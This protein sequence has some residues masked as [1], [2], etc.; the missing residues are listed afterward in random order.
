MPVFVATWRFG[1]PACRAGWRILDAGGS[2]LDAVEAGGN[3]VEEDISVMSVGRGGL[4]N[5]EGVVELDA[6][7]MDGRT[8][9]AGAVGA[10]PGIA[11]AISVARRV[12]DRTPHV[13]LAG[14]N[15]LRFALE[16]GF[17]EEDLSSAESRARRQSWLDEQKAAQVA[18][19]EMPSALSPDE[20]HDTVGLLALDAN[21][22]LAAG[23]TTSGL[24]WKR[25]GRVGDSPIVGSGLYVD[26][27]FGAAAATGHGDEMMKACLSYRVVDRMASG[28]TPEEACVEAVRYLQ[29]VR[30][31]EL[32]NG[33]GAAVIA[34]RKDGLTGAAGTR[35]G[36]HAPERLWLWA[37][38]DS[39]EPVLHEG[40]YAAPD[41]LI[42]G[43]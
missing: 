14:S 22:E 13:M 43:L 23:C 41:C 7:I 18:H 26:N 37:T 35:T 20:S 36:F 25:P 21:G 39:A 15:A 11:R 29:S 38:A 34:L 3:V 17:V 8:H 12:M 5:S 30:P 19:F 32:H 24:A 28:M 42:A 31:P 27:R 40:P 4:P 2:A 1:L 9:D 16:E 33:Y 6:A 10:L